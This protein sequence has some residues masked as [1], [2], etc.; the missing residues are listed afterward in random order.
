MLKN[1]PKILAVLIAASVSAI[2]VAQYLALSG[3]IPVSA[4][5]RVHW[6]FLPAYSI[7]GAFGVMF[8]WF[9]I[10]AL[11]VYITSEI[12]KRKRAGEPSDADGAPQPGPA[13]RGATMVGR[14]PPSFGRRPR[15]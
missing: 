5:A 2:G 12:G 15:T 13:Q 4:L 1:H 8:Q 10:A 11:T 9:L 7:G 6:I 3:L 14:N